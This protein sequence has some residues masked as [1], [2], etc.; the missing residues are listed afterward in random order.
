MVVLDTVAEKRN[1]VRQRKRWKLLRY[2][3]S[4][5]ALILVADRLAL[6]VM[7]VPL[8]AGLA[9]VVR[10]SRVVLL[11][12][13]SIPVFILLADGFALVV[14][15]IPLETGL[16][17]VVRGLVVRRLQGM[18]LHAVVAVPV[19]VVVTVVRRKTAFLNFNIAFFNFIAPV[20]LLPALAV[21]RTKNQIS[22]LR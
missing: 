17:E 14:V 12:A 9:E 21:N 13:V 3:L 10:R 19:L 16:A 8:E 11:T 22:G 1:D 2:L 6:V 4:V 20:V 5:P 7:V 15:I 18:V